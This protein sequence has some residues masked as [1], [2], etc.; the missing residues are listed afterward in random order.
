MDKGEFTT[1]RLANIDKVILLS[2]YHRTCYPMIPE[3]KVLYSGNG[4]DAEEFDDYDGIERDPHKMVYQSSHV[5]GLQFLYEIWPDIK[6]AVPDATLDVYYGWYS[7][8]KINAGNPERMAW[9]DRMVQQERSLDGVTDHGKVDQLEIVRAASGAGIWA[10]PTTFPEIYCITAVK[11]Q[12]AGAVPVCSD[13]AA[14]DEMVQYGEKIPLYPITE[15]KLEHYKDRLIW[16]LQHPEEQDKQRLAMKEW[17]RTLTW[18]NTA[19]GWIKD[20]EKERSD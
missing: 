8:D 6:K 3:E 15:Q 13:Y 20:F 18:R 2:K 9:K 12:A 5:R 4:I 7:Y 1:E 14:L 17:A 11:C 10:Y 16:W 19:E